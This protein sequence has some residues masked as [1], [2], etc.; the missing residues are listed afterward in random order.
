MSPIVLTGLALWG[1][2]SWV[3]AGVGGAGEVSRAPEPAAKGE[4]G[5]STAPSIAPAPGAGADAADKDSKVEPGAKLDAADE[6]AA[7][8]LIKLAARQYDEG[9]FDEAL[10]TLEGA[11]AISARPS[12]AYNIGQVQRARNDCAGALAAY[13]TFL[14][15]TPP[16][17]PNHDRASRWRAEMQKC[18]DE[19]AALAPASVST[20]STGSTT[21]PTA[22]RAPMP[23]ATESVPTVSSERL[24]A[25]LAASTP[26]PSLVGAR[27]MSAATITGW[28]LIGAGAVAGMAALLLQ[29]KASSIQNDLDSHEHYPKDIDRLLADGNRDARLALGAVIGAGV[30]AVT[31]GAVLVVSHQT[32]P[33]PRAMAI[34]GWAEA[35]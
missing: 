31:G 2:M 26:A 33:S 34:I 20:P 16:L 19:R 3:P 13:Q 12:I 4:L 8:E 23:V 14:A 22:V 28:S 7:T 21:E 6:A 25:G 5:N 18:V 11:R 17:D 1:V 15:M 9:R 29:L 32:A 24:A 27:R 35:F 30:L 10:R